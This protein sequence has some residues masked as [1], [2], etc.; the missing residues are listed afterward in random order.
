MFIKTL[1]IHMK[2]CVSQYARYCTIWEIVN[3]SSLNAIISF[4]KK[5]QDYNGFYLIVALY[6]EFFEH[7]VRCRNFEIESKF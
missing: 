3:L 4:K 7:C 6:F 2:I 1:K 5:K